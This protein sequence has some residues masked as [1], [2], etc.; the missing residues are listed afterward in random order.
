MLRRFYAANTPQKNAA[1]VFRESKKRAQ[2]LD[3]EPA[4]GESA[5]PVSRVQIRHLD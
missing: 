5:E 3:G 4:C 2:H 1:T